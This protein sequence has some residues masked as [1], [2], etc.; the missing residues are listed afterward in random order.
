MT[1]EIAYN[2]GMASPKMHIDWTKLPAGARV[3]LAGKS[4][5]NYYV[6]TLPSGKKAVV[7][8]SGHD[9]CEAQRELERRVRTSRT[10]RA[11]ETR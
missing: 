5:A 2:L 7:I 1:P 9:A 8:W 11:Q 4:G 3:A 6:A 10:T